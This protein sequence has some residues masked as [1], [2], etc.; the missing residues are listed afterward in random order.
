MKPELYIETADINT[1]L[2]TFRTEMVVTTGMVIIKIDADLKKL[3]IAVILKIYETMLVSAFEKLAN[4]QYD[5]VL[6]SH[7]L[8]PSKWPI[9]NIRLN[10][11]GKRIILKYDFTDTLKFKVNI[12]PSLQGDKVKI[13]ALTIL[14]NCLTVIRDFLSQE[15]G[16]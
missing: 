9:L 4:G 5:Q 14:S 16:G 3:S 7:K 12:R 6:Y 1:P 2:G 15:N 11:Y 10:S 8:L 13:F